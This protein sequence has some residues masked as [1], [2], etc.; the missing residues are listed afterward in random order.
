MQPFYETYRDQPKLSAPLKELHPDAASVFRDSYLVEFLGFP[1]FHSEDDLQLGLVQHLKKFLIELGR[2]F[3]FVGSQYPVQIG[4]RDFLLDLLYFNRALNCLVAIELKVFEFEPEHP[5]KLQ[6]YLEALDR[7][8]KKS[9]EQP[10]I[11]VPLCD[12]SSQS[13]STC[14]RSPQEKNQMQ[15]GHSFHVAVSST[16]H[17]RDTGILDTRVMSLAIGTSHLRKRNL[18]NNPA[19]RNAGAAAQHTSQQISDCDPMETTDVIG[20]KSTILVDVELLRGKW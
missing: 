4:G 9:H 13:R 1:S 5:G 3:Y 14:N 2:D 17:D 18:S 12:C 7:D 10:S 15:D 16:R 19:K 8:V 11:G 20:P 6:F